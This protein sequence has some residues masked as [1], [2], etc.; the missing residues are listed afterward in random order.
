MKRLHYIQHVPFETP[1]SIV[2][3][4]NTSGV[5]LSSTRTFENEPMPDPDTFD[6]LVVMGGPM[7]VHDDAKYGW[8]KAEKNLIEST[9]EADKPV[10][11][12]CLGAQ[13]LA[14]VL[15][16]RV[17]Q[18]SHKEI[19][20]YSVTTTAE[21]GSVHAT[22]T[23][24]REFTA[25]H[26]HGDMF[27]IPDGAKRIA[28]SEAC[29]N[30]GFAY[31]DRVIGLQFHLEVTGISLIA[32]AEN[33]RHELIADKYVQTEGSVLRNR[34]FISTNNKY[35]SRIMSNLAGD[36]CDDKAS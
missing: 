19:G 16:A 29:M 33:G 17:F 31:H 10:L 23:L 24:P 14:D 34:E 32:M 3:W 12:I 15:G 28:A 30:Q 8:L 11:G 36:L 25:F 13:L 22:G 26:W 7:G 9:V 1:G 27:D 20:W 4:A 18:N 2:D 21:N 5:S 35:M 6:I